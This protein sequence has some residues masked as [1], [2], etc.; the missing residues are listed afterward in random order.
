[1]PSFQPSFPLHPRIPEDT[2]RAAQ[3]IRE[4]EISEGIIDHS[5][6]SEQ[7]ISQLKKTP[8][9]RRVLYIVVAIVVLLWLMVFILGVFGVHFW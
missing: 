8:P 6:L 5:G 1:M 4:Q 9:L 7:E 3:E 2:E